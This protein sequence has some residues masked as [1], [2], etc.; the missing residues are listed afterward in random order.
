MAIITTSYLAK[1]TTIKYTFNCD[2]TDT[3]KVYYM[4]SSLIPAIKPAYYLKKKV[5][6]SSSFSGPRLETALSQ[7]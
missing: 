5:T 2:H 1:T 6:G 4:H 3:F 7:L